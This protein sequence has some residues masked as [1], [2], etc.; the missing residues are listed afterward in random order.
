[1]KKLF[2]AFFLM[3]LSML[4]YA[5]KNKH[6][7]VVIE[8][9]VGTMKV[10]VY[11]EV[12]Q[13]AENFLKLVDEGQLTP[14]NLSEIRG[15]LKY[16]PWSNTSIENFKFY[17]QMIKQ[18]NEKLRLNIPIEEAHHFFQDEN[19]FSYLSEQNKMIAAHN[20]NKIL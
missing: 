17:I 12:K 20:K 14:E 16:T 3:S 18:F 13:H 19:N 5:K 1:M 8:T 15:S 4:S 7:F 11:P 2:L 6:K 10:E 9:T